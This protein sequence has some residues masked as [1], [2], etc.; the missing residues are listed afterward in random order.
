MRNKI[1]HYVTDKRE[2][3]EYDPRVDYCHQAMLE[4]GIA[5]R[6]IAQLTDFRPFKLKL[7]YETTLSNFAYQD[8]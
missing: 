6:V 3:I 1:P 4:N 2:T 7:H 8:I 5:V